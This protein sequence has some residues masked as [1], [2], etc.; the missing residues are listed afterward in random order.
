M[1]KHLYV[2]AAAAI[3]K[4]NS[5]LYSNRNMPNTGGWQTR[6]DA[7]IDNPVTTSFEST[8]VKMLKGWQEYAMVHKR[9]YDSLI[10]EDGV[11]GLEWEAIGDSL[12]GILNGQAGRL[13]CGT[14]DSFILN[15]MTE[16]GVD[17]SHK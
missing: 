10:G 1:S 3:R 12:R 13:D 5:T 2:S 9:E 14:L 15:T 11:L 4:A 16:N 7:A 8:L 17:T 6:H